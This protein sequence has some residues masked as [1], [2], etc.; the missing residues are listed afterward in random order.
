MRFPD[1]LPDGRAHRSGSRATRRAFRRAGCPGPQHRSAP[2]C[3]G[4]C[5]HGWYGH[6]AKCPAIGTDDVLPVEDEAAVFAHYGLPYEAGANGERQ[7]ARR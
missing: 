7:L 5:H 1:R 2:S 3:N 6:L 4:K